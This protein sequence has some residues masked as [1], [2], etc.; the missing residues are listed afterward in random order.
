MLKDK[1]PNTKLLKS[2][3]QALK[4]SKCDISTKGNIMLILSAVVAIKAGCS[5]DQFASVAQAWYDHEKEK[6][7]PKKGGKPP[8][9]K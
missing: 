6:G 3:I 2:L 5:K 4:R 9:V 8:Y 7:Y 1:S